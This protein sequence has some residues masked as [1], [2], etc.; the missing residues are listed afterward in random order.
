VAVDNNGNPIPDVTAP[1]AT[2]GS[3]LGDILAGIGG[4]PVN[5]AAIGGTIANGQALNG[6]RTAQTENSLLNAQAARD[7]ADARSGL[8]GALLS[9]GLPSAQAHLQA[10]EMISKSGNAQQAMAAYKMQQDTA[11]RG[12]L[13]SPTATPQQQVL[14][15]QGIEG[16]V[17]PLQNVPNQY[18]V[19]AGQQAP[20]V[21]V[22][23]MG[24]ADINEKNAL[25]GAATARAANAG[26]GQMDAAAAP[27][28][29]RFI[30]QNPASAQNLR[31]LVSNGGS[32]VGV[33][34][35]AEHGDPEAAALMQ[36]RY[37]QPPSGPASPHTS[38]NPAL[39]AG[40][41]GTMPGSMPPGAAEPN[42][43]YHTPPNGITPSPGM[44]LSE[45]AGIRKDFSSGVGARQVTALN[46]AF[47]HSV[48]MDHLADQLGNGNFTPTNAINVEW[49]R[50]F[51]GPAPSN[52]QTAASFLGREAVRATVNSGAGTEEERGLQ[53]S[54]NASPDQMHG[55]AQ[56][57]RALLG[58]Q[59]HSLDMRARSGGKDISPML[60][61]EARQAYGL[62]AQSP[63]L[64]TL[65]APS[66]ATPGLPSA[67]DIA[68]E[69]ARRG[70]Q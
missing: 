55:V 62:G 37:G 70:V 6:L 67:G 50:L 14:A 9:S 39:P 27:I 17:A 40:A 47:Q 64:A 23:P 66:T 11:N 20:V 4:A 31:S 25:G 43:P 38:P 61:P 53:M 54:A 58:G 10:L 49:Q 45:Q 26:G 21:H 12:V 52:L 60:S 68:A 63:A 48:L 15:Q 1:A 46:T 56:T 7:E 69:L 22:S 34:W 65:A 3:G 41:P 19:P 13:S 28:L 51:G 8:E 33:A 42:A 16:K 44:S 2:G 24:Q 18:A 32:M 29:A 35:M 5:R 36:S 30:D 57:I 59:L